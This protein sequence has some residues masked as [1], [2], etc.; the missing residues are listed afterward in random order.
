MSERLEG[1]VK[2]AKLLRLL[3]A[4]LILV[5]LI[6]AAFKGYNYWQ[7]QRRPVAEDVRATVSPGLES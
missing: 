1:L 5:A 2:P 6:T 4:V 7:A 3:V